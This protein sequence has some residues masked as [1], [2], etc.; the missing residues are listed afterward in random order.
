MNKKTISVSA[1]ALLVIIFVTTCTSI[2]YHGE[3]GVLLNFGKPVRIITRPGLVFRYPYPFHSMQILDA[4]MTILEPK[5]SEFLTADKKNLILENSLCYKIN[6]PILFMKTVRDKI[7]LEIRLTDLLSSHT[8]LLLGQ[9][10]LSD[11]VN[12]DPQKIRYREINRQLTMLMQRDTDGLGIEIKEV[13]IRRI[14]LPEMNRYSVFQRMR[15]ERDR[16]AKKYIAEGNEQGQK[17]RAEAD[18]TSRV[19]I[20]EAESRALVIKGEAEAKAMKLYGDTYSKNPE[21]FQFYRS[22]EAY[23]KVFGDKST[24]ILDSDAPI[25]KSLLKEPQP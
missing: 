17:I 1:L 15:A 19:M 20:A 18:K 16:I 9:F 7:G 3:I 14:M 21:F 12:V 24:L 22:M 4:R 8:G 6:D 10:E 13:F 25:L 11:L 5:P 2:V 23:Q